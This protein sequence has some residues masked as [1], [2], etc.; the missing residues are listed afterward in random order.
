VIVCIGTTVGD[1]TL[2]YKPRDSWKN[3]TKSDLRKLHNNKT[4]G[5]VMV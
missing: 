1:N 5:N 4:L 2:Y 3:V